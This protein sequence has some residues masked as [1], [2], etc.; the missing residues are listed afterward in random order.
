[1]TYPYATQQQGWSSFASELDA[2]ALGINPATLLR[3]QYGG[4]ISEAIDE[5]TV[6]FLM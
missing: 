5:L 6:I 4:K 1:M 2:L 3:G